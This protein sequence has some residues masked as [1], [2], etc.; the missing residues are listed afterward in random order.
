MFSAE[1]IA[2]SQTNSFTRIVTD[3]LAGAE[4]LQPFY[5]YR[6]DLAGIKAALQA[7]KMSPEYREV[8]ASALTSQ[9]ATVSA[10]NIVNENIGALREA[11][12]FTVTTA[13]QPNLLTGPLYFIY[14]IL[15]AIKLA[16]YLTKELPGNRFVPVF[17][18]GSE[19]ADLDELNHFNVQGKR[20]TWATK[21]QGAVGRMVV[22][23]DISKLLAELDGQIGG[24]PFG[25]GLM[26]VFQQC[27]SEGR[28]IQDATFELV[29]A[30]FGRF[31]LVVLIADEPS[32]KRTMQPV[33][34]ADL[35]EQQSAKIVER[36]SAQLNVHYNVQAYARPIN[37]FYL[38][39]GL[40]NRIEQQ[41]D[42]FR[43][44]DT[45]ISFSKTDIQ[46]E[47][48]SH[49]ERFSPN[50]ILRG[51]YQETILP[52]VAFIGG[53]G[54]IAYW[55]QLK[56]LFIHYK[57]PFPVLVLRNSF[58]VVEIQ[59][60]ELAKSLNIDS[61]ALFID[62]L[63]LMN[64]HLARTGQRPQLNSEAEAMEAIY[65][66]LQTQAAAVDP[67]LEKH[68]E[69]LHARANNQLQALEQK[70][71]RAA[72]RREEATGRQ[73]HKLKQQL[74]PK[75]GLQERVENFSSF[76]AAHGPQ[77]IDGLLENSGALEQRFTLLYQNR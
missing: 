9:Y 30:L 67:T 49:P 5:T 14:K 77:W 72:R 31:G 62:E 60:R 65:R 6:P 21:Q 58:L 74:F 47:L 64:R 4:A 27:F 55:L 42:V 61:E 38:A 8:L 56:D 69:A 76:Y 46:N 32:L 71:L 1:S 15:H 20:Y 16:S 34:E 11:K 66:N 63:E 26:A 19:D 28:L 37:L 12:T 57:V 23:K 70:M 22:D 44:V 41:G 18:M 45:A 48:E 35:F 7:R 29:H 52:N 59:Q 39:D 10:V 75:N 73:I 43:V 68:V 53:G 54:E 25:P 50:V 40:R 13:H 3:Y 2:Y 51:L 36:T 17:Y 24:Q 33:F